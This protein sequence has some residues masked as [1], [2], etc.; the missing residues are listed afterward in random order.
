MKFLLDQGIPRSLKELLISEGYEA[1]HVGIIG[2]GQANDLDII[3]F[4]KKEGYIC[5]TLDADFHMI[6]ALSKDIYPSV[7]RIRIEN[8]KAN[9]H[10]K[11]I[12]TTLPHI[13]ESLISGALVSIRE[14]SI[15]IRKLPI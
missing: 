7:I 3:E 12:K 4:A 14:D 11:L 6:L 13:T 1:E 10:L 15:G 2:M 9:D 8:L 5:I